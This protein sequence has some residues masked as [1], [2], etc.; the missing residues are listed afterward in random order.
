L[1]DIGFPQIDADFPAD[2]ANLRQ[3]A[4]KSAL[5]CGKSCAN[6]RE[7]LRQSAGKSCADL[8]ENQRQSAGNPAP[9]CGKIRVN[10][11]ENQH[12]SAGKSAPICGKISVNLRETDT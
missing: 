4:G 11:R 9:I 3:S 5:I 1:R 2:H 7:T 8:R 12:R 6:L 10:L